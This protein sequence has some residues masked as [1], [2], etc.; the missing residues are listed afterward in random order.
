MK[1]VINGCH[2]GF[3]LSSKALLEYAKRKGIALYFYGNLVGEHLDKL[4]RLTPEERDKHW[5]GTCTTKDLGE[6]VSKDAFHTT[7]YDCSFSMYDIPRNDPDLIAVVESIGKD[8][9]GEYSE[10]KIVEI[11]DDVDFE[12]MEYD[13]AEWVAEKHRTWS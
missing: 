13:G 8:A 1:V 11:P 9:G 3:G 6:T 4:R 12:I 7:S 2:G 5:F 10:L